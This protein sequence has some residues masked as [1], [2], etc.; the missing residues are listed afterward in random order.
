MIDQEVVGIR[1]N[2]MNEIWI[3]YVS[4]FA[5]LCFLSVLKSNYAIL[6]KSTLSTTISDDYNDLKQERNKFL[7]NVR[8]KPNIIVIIAD[9]MGWND[10]SF[11]GS[12]QIPTPNIDALAYNG[13]ILNSHYVSP[14]CTPSRAT[15]LTGKY[16]TR[17]GLQHSVLLHA[18]P[19]GLPLNETLLPQYLKK[20]G[21]VT[22]AVGK[23]HLGYYKKVY[24]P[25][26][27]GF[28]TFFG[29]YNGL[30][31]Y[32]THNSADLSEPNALEG[33]DMRRNLSIAWDTLNKYSTDLFTEESV[34]LINSHDTKDPMFLYLAHLAPHSGNSNDL[35]QAP[36]EEIAKFGYINDPERRIYAGR[37]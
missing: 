2:E 8:Q 24:T 25:T 1:I 12:N 22:H 30:Q 19:R 20:A 14:L 21:Y 36:D 27:R 11:H 23:W 7:H 16:P 29:Y 9:D 17:L 31:D 10:V 33:F 34:R 28:D 6:Q 35:L 26:Y 3:S 18:E 13:V 4:L 5:A 37:Y 15:L 32:Y